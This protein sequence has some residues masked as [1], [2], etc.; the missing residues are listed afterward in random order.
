MA[1]IRRPSNNVDSSSVEAPRR[2]LTSVADALSL[3]ALD[4][5]AL[6]RT[7]KRG[8]TGI[9]GIIPLMR[10]TSLAQCFWLSIGEKGNT[11]P[12]RVHG[13]CY[14]GGMVAAAGRREGYS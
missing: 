12:T 10:S 6:R 4:V 2:Q 3:A 5:A 9:M 8:E 13:S 7:A 14:V 11:P 1:T